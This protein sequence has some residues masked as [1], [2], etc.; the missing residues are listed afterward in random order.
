MKKLLQCINVRSERC[1]RFVPPRFQGDMPEGVSTGFVLV[2]EL[3]PIAFIWRMANRY[4][5]KIYLVTLLGGLSVMFSAQAQTPGTLLLLSNAVS[6]HCSEVTN[7]P[8]GLTNVVSVAVGTCHAVALAA[9]GRAFRWGD[10]NLSIPTN[11]LSNI[12]AVSANK[13]K[14]LAL[15]ADGTVTAWGW[16]ITPSNQ[17]VGITNLIAIDQGH[18]CALGITAEGKVVVWGDPAYTNVPVGLSNIVAI[19]AASL[20]FA[21]SSAG[22]VSFWGPPPLEEV[23]LPPPDLSNVVAVSSGDF[24]SM[25]LLSDGTVRSWGESIGPIPRGLSNI[26]AIETGYGLELALRQD[27]TLISRGPLITIPPHLPFISAIGAD[28]SD[29]LLVVNTNLASSPPQ[30]ISSPRS[31]SASLGTDVNLSV[32]AA[33]YGKLSYQWFFNGTNS[34]SG[35]PSQQLKLNS[36]Q[37]SQSG[38]Y[39]VVVSNTAGAVTSSVALVQVFVALQDRMAPAI[40]L[41]GQVGVTYQLEYVN[42]VESGTNWIPVAAVTL[43][44]NPQRYIDL[45]AIDQPKRFYRLTL[46]P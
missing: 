26:V 38:A 18:S 28:G 12:V 22:K 19:E 29:V 33:G 45:S 40:T 3:N 6:L 5:M 23:H 31:Q 8:A 39:G 4:K 41:N 17:P 27:G 25:A 1:P 34:I 16:G 32:D 14:G 11:V 10:P 44:N 46:S 43:T 7:M 21:V 2:Q 36:I 20:C 15:R 35:A 9:D 37:F 13:F 30:I 42:A 24:H